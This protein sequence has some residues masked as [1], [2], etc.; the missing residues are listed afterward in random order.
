MESLW[1]WLNGFNPV[2]RAR[3]QATVK[4]RVTAACSV[5]K[6]WN[7]YGILLNDYYQLNNQP[8]PKYP[9]T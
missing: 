8:I 6:S 7:I 5:A 1:N 3:G 2:R 4:Q 9:S